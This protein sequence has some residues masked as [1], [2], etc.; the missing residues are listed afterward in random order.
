MVFPS[1]LASLLLAPPH[2]SVVTCAAA[3]VPPVAVVFSA[4][5]VLRVSA[6]SGVSALVPDVVGVTAFASVP[7]VVNMCP[8]VLV[9]LL[10]LVFPVVP[11][12]SSPAVETAVDVFLPLLFLV[13]SKDF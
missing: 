3:V 4:V 1:V 13:S 11:G 2:V 9:P 10:L 7:T 5:N 6:V 8:P 12:V